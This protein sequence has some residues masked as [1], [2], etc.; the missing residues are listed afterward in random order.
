MA[1]RTNYSCYQYTA[2]INSTANINTATKYTSTSTTGL[3]NY[4]SYV[5]WI[6]TTNTCAPSEGAHGTECNGSTRQTD[7]WCTDHTNHLDHLQHKSNCRCA[8]LCT[9]CIVQIQPKTNGLDIADF[10]APT[11]QHEL[12]H[13]DHTD[14]T[15][16][17]CMSEISALK[18]LGHQVGMVCPRFYQFYPQKTERLIR[19]HGIKCNGFLPSMKRLH[20][21]PGIAA[22]K[23]KY[24]NTHPRSAQKS[25]GPY[26]GSGGSCT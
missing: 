16:Q 5:P 23:Q 15:D 19:Q 3:Y 22:R 18:E 25:S 12:D 13:T 20:V 1:P 26:R 17:E 7:R 11:R 14:H 4:F 2:A 10:A 24:W 6:P 8:V 21:S 9:I